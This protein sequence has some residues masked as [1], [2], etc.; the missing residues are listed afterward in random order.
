MVDKKEEIVS[1]FLKKILKNPEFLIF[2]ELVNT[3]ESL[4]NIM[5]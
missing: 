1:F 5:D 4:L 3:L 2:L